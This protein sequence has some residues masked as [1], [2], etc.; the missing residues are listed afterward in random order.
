MPTGDP[1]CDACGAY[2][3]SCTCRGVGVNPFTI[4]QDKFQ[5]MIAAEKEL[6]K[7]PAPLGV[8]PTFIWKEKRIK[9]LLEASQRYIGYNHSKVREWL[10]EALDILPDDE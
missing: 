4:G 9:A 3:M 10:V 8:M 2:L 1:I 6:I 7:A 5:E